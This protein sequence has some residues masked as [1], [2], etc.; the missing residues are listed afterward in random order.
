[1]QTIKNRNCFS[2]P[3]PISETL[4]QIL[5]SRGKVVI[6]SHQNPDG[7]AIGS[8]LGLALSLKQAGVPVTVV[9][10][11]EAPGFLKWLPGYRSVLHY[12]KDKKAVQ[13]AF[14]QA[15]LLFLV[16]LSHPD[17]LGEM[18]ALLPAFRG[19]SIQ[20]DHHP[21]S[22]GFTSQVWICQDYGSTAEIIF[23]VLESIP[24]VDQMSAEAATCLLTGIITDTLGF[25]VASSYPG[26]FRV[27]MELMS[28][29]ADKDQIFDQ[30]YNQ[31]HEGR[32]R[33]LGFSLSER[34]KV[35]PDQ[36]AA[37]ICLTRKD[38]ES[39]RYF[40]GD[41]EGF[42]N[43]PLTMKRVSLSVFMTEL[44]DHIKLSFRSK[45]DVDVNRLARDHF[46]GGGHQNAAGGRFYGTME[47]ALHH[48][49]QVISGSW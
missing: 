14:E 44:D 36:Q 8:A 49:E 27:V 18:A 34:M 10:P 5:S 20:L 23:H 35:Y 4:K 1:M 19:T 15:V 26:V 40:K 38:M 33:L 39:F 29:G 43:Y 48:F 24:M 7:D 6:A 41:T 25:R 13:E 45:G 46:H 22:G 3:E 9:L 42:V 12:E 28:R 30:V 2:V 21:G 31:S 11:D 17:R 37:C 16:D 47:E 32:L